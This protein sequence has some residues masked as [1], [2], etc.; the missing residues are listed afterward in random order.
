MSY[1]TVLQSLFETARQCKI[2]CRLERPADVGTA[3]LRKSFGDDATLLIDRHGFFGAENV[4]WVAE[5]LSIYLP[6]G[7][8]DRQAGYAFNANSGMTDPSWDARKYVIASAS[9]DPITTD[10]SGVVFVSVHGIG[11]WDYDPAFPSIASFLEFTDNWL[12]YFLIEKERRIFTEDLDF[13]PEVSEE[14]RA[15]IPDEVSTDMRDNIIEF[16]F[17]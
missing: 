17:G 14:T 3:F 10:A 16:M 5:H 13:L 1:E 6:H 9:A 11:K 2:D 4:P 15:I 12:K 8:K 7:P